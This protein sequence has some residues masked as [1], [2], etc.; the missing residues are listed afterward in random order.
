MVMAGELPA[1]SRAN[2][3]GL[4]NQDDPGTI[5]DAQV[6]LL[7]DRRRCCRRVA[8]DNC[9]GRSLLFAKFDDEVFCFYPGAKC[10]SGMALIF[11][12]D[13]SFKVI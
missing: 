11:F 1:R 9:E 8:E 2:R 7:R 13:G 5:F 10:V 6:K 4:S 12:A 3:S